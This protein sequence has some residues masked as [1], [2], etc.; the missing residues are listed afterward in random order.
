MIIPKVPRL[1]LAK[2]PKEPDHPTPPETLVGHLDDVFRVAKSIVDNTGMRLLDTMGLP[3]SCLRQLDQ[4]LC[5]A[6]LLHDLGK[7]NSQFQRAL[8][9]GNR[10]PQALRHEWV[11]AWLPLKFRDLDRWLFSDCSQE[12]KWSV[13]F[14]VLGHHLK[15]K[16][17]HGAV[18]KEQG[19]SGD[20]TVMVFCNH[21][22]FRSCLDSL[23][24]HQKKTNA[25][26]VLPQIHIDLLDRPLPELRTWL[27]EAQ[28]WYQNV[29]HETKRFVA[30]V[31]ALTIAADV[32]GSAVPRAGIDP[33]KWAEEV[34]R[35]TC[36]P[37]ELAEIAAASLD[38]QK[39]RAFQVNVA[40]STGRVVFTKA[41]CGTGKTLAAYLWAASRAAGRK[42][43]FCYPTTG[44]ATEGFRDYIIPAEMSS[45][46]LLLHSRSECDLEYLRDSENDPLE[47]ASRIESLSAWD[48][49]L[50]ICTVDQVL[51]L[52]QNY[53]R[54]LF[55]FPT[56]ATGAFVFDEIHQYDDRLFGA[57]LSFLDI[58]RGAPT[59]L[60][61]ASLPKSRLQ[62]IKKILAQRSESL[63]IIE[64]P[65]EL[66]RI[67]RYIL[68]G[69]FESPDWGQVDKALK[70]EGK[71]LWV[72]N[73][74]D[75]CVGFAEEAEAHGFHP[76]PY[77]SRYRYCDRLER[78]KAVIEAFKK[79]GGTLAV[80]TQVC[81]VSLNISADLLITDLAPI[82]ALIQRL[83][84]LNRRVTIE[85]P[86]KPK[87]AILLTPDSDRPYHASEFAATQKWLDGLGAA[88][89]SQEALAQAFEK[90]A[91][92]AVQ[93]VKS[94]WFE[95]GPLS[96]QAPV[97]DAE[98]TIPVI[99]E[100][101]QCFCVD[102]QRRPITKEITRYAIP[103]LLGPVAKEIS[104]WKRLSFT[105]VAPQGRI[106]YSER[107]GAKWSK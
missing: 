79:P 52:I 20:S 62:T 25:G 33:G 18:L 51:G 58:F 49:P 16:D 45:E 69:P 54:P 82:P 48:I 104:G 84:R 40:H 94:A 55:S 83:G 73:T 107:L 93:S 43:F 15:L 80:T 71:V 21:A 44:T 67:P 95:G 77:H 4:A 76:L 59:L 39:P 10:P 63:E 50:I 60:M 1:L 72:A 8:A 85:N 53:R 101:D 34:L 97:R 89:L 75:R 56:I 27:P 64:G 13:L 3:C 32:A 96:D 28:E 99:R 47:S 103:M 78:H 68:E 11:S 92:S 36:L 24:K 98:S 9:P 105:F 86:G 100:E 23:A 12:V 42:L 70:D 14:A 37:N 46:A 22:D 91:E 65:L 2:P 41:G 7:A 87:P 29:S 57:L 17:K 6:A 19:G 38:G 26:P 102:E 106:N 66:E 61:T 88:A 30:A 35:R 81:E 74:V 90:M 5:L 31:K